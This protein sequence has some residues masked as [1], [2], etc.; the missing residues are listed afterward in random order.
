MVT[1]TDPQSVKLLKAV[2][3]AS[4]GVAIFLLIIKCVAWIMTDSVSIQASLVDSLVDTLA[5]LVNFF[6]IRHALVPADKEH[7]FGHGKIE[8]I[9]AQAQSLFISGTALWLGFEAL[10]RFAHPEPVQETPLGLSI[11]TV[12]IIITLA[13]VAFQKYVIA[14]TNSTVIKADHLHFKG[15][16]F[17]N[18]SVIASLLLSSQVGWLFIDPL[19]G[20][21]IGGYIMYT[22]WKIAK[23]AFHILIDRELPD[24][25]RKKIQDIVMAHTNVLGFHGLK[26]RTS[27]PSRFIQLHLEMDGNMSLL[28]AHTIAHEVSHSL[29][30][31]FPQTEVIIH[32]DPWDD[33]Y[34]D[35]LLKQ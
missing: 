5:S 21:L 32:Q 14:R 22:S 15:D 1:K 10:H 34:E 20:L 3:Y 25:E 7:R 13:L 8:A 27:G 4:V 19:C 26:T 28:K 24:E 16:L 12:T 18:L 17:L 29:E 23:E 31:A 30:T 2:T 11:I 9:A 33:S 6:A 35:G